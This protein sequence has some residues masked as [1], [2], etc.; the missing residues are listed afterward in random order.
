MEV[1]GGNSPVDRSFTTPGLEFWIHSRPYEQADQG[2]DVYYASSCASGRITRLLLADVSGHGERVASV[3][4]GLRDLMRQNINVINQTRFVREMN[5]QFSAQPG[6]V[7]LATALVCTFFSP[8]RRLQICNA[9]HPTPLL[10]R[11]GL[12][13]WGSVLAAAEVEQA[14]GFADTPLGVSEATDYSRFDTQLYPGDMVLCV[15]DAFT[16]SRD[17][18][19]ELLGMN[20]LM[21]ILEHL[22]AG[23]PADIVPELVERVEDRYEGNL[24]QDDA[25]ALL[26]RADG[27]KVPL[28]NNF[29]APLRIFNGVRDTMSDA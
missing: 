29:L 16:E 12:G 24:R 13:S 21:A 28:K 25:T 1:W 8:T 10:Y 26:F 14:V 2:G 9:G 4:A 18:D 6:H 17:R 27:S 11:A 5:R 7:K 23:D 3:A 20:G 22:E 15:S 19:G